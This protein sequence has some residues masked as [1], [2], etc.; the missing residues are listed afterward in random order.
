MCIVDRDSDDG[1]LNHRTNPYLFA[2]DGN[3]MEL[4]A[5]TPAV[6]EKFLLVALAGFPITAGS[7]IPKMANILEALFAIRQAN[8]RLG[9]GMT[10]IPFCGY[11]RIDA[12]DLTFKEDAFVRAYLQKNSQWQQREAFVA[13][14]TEIQRNLNPELIKRV[15]GHDLAELLYVVV[16]KFR[17][18]RAFTN[19]ALLEGCLM[20]SV[21]SRDLE[22]HSLFVSL[23]Q[24]AVAV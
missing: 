15:R 13:V 22:A 7:L 14:K 1:M 8:E 3:S 6:I 17:K 11:I 19:S 16:R 21:E 4:Y 2:T 9:L 24:N 18:E 23:E 12:F 5:L 10:W 20:T